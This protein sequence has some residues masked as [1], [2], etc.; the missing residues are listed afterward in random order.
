MPS[1]F[2]FRAELEK[3]K[4]AI[5]A[6]A[7]QIYTHAAT[8]RSPERYGSGGMTGAMGAMARGEDGEG[9]DGGAG[10]EQ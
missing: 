4:A 10:G 2:L 3:R 8:Q 6:R 1:C 5:E 7:R 9:G